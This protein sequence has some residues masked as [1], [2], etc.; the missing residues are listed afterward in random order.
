LNC[1]ILYLSK[2]VKII[3]HETFGNTLA[4][5]PHIKLQ[6]QAKLKAAVT[7]IERELI[8]QQHDELHGNKAELARRLGIG[9]TTLWRKLKEV[10]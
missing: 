2:V 8:L 5:V 9:R 6:K 10:E 4:S 3:F 7:D 1:L